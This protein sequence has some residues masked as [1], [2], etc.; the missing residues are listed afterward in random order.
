MGPDIVPLLIEEFRSDPQDTVRGTVFMV[1]C[2]SGVKVIAH[3]DEMMTA[4]KS[5]AQPARLLIRLPANVSRRL[6]TIPSA[7]DRRQSRPQGR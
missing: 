5:G 6:P 2:E 4:K 1:L 7:A 3:V